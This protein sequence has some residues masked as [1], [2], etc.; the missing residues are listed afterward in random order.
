VTAFTVAVSI[1]A[2]PER[3]LAVLCDVERWPEWTPTMTSVQRLDHGPFGIGSS[4]RIVQPKLRP[5]VWQVTELDKNRSFTWVARA[6]GVR[7]KAAHFVEPEGDGSRAALSFEFSGL[8]G[9]VLSRIY[10]GL[11]Q[12]YVATEAKGL[13][14]RSETL[15]H[16]A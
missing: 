2:P 14:Q 3:V 4:A 13:K 16:P 1:N 5:A 8:L 6:P 7:M 15:S 12:Q 11:I 10:R 9:P